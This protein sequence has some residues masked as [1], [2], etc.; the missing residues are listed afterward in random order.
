MVYG[1]KY[2]TRGEVYISGYCEYDFVLTY[3]R[4]NS[5]EITDTMGKACI[6][7]F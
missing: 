7:I 1:W 4:A 2:K 3:T 6:I 5:V